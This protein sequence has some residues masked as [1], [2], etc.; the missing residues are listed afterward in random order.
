MKKELDFI[1][2]DGTYYGGDQNWH[3]HKMMKLG[4]CSAV[5]AC[6]TCIWLAKRFGEYRALYPFDIAD[7]CKKDF[8]RFFEIMFQYLHPGIGGLTSI[9]KFERM[10]GKYIMTTGTKMGMQK[11]YGRESYETAK[12]FFI[13]S[14]DNGIPVMFLMLKHA[15]PAFDEYEWH[16]FNLTGYEITVEGRL[17]AIFATWGS[18][19]VFDFQRAWETGRYWK[20]GMV[21]FVRP[22][23]A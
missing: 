19:H 3:T 6:E 13:S 10:L 4:G 18:R 22:E 2:I 21:A 8:L 17:N 9:D 12:K 14:I 20:G 1:R 7:V 5:C 23:Y 11:V 15:D 16:W